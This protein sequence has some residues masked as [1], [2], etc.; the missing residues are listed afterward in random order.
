MRVG[1]VERIAERGQLVDRDA[2]SGLGQRRV[3]AT[4]RCCTP[5]P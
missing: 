3:A 4:K 5:K 1:L 2:R